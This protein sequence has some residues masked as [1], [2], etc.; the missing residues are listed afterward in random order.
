MYF[1]DFR[2]SILCEL[3]VRPWYLILS[4]LG[5]IIFSTAILFDPVLMGDECVLATSIPIT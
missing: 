3:R 1:S 2:S 4:E 5:N